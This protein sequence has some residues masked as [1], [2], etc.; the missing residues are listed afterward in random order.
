MPLIPL[1]EGTKTPLSGTDVDAIL[2]GD[3][4]PEASLRIF[5]KHPRLNYGVACRN[6]LFAVDFD[7][8]EKYLV[9]FPKHQE[10][11]A[12]TM[13]VLSPHR[14]C[15]VW[16]RSSEEIRR[17]LGLAKSLDV[18]ALGG[19]AV[20]PASVLDHAKCPAD[21]I[22]CPHVGLGTYA[23]ID[24]HSIMWAEAYFPGV[25]IVAKLE[26]RAKALG[27]DFRKNG[28]SLR[29]IVKQGAAPGERHEA[30]KKYAAHLIWTV[31]LD[32]DTALFELKRWDE[33][34]N[35]PPISSDPSRGHELQSIIEWVADRGPGARKSHVIQEEDL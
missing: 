9:F 3:I 8:L 2:A 4:S 13:I 33:K 25:S 5:E 28:P 31:K 35:R 27:W 23:V 14:G 15:H 22:G 6:G 17:Q 20:G 26:E 10:L 19:Y 30:A 21:K 18:L 11:E 12:R 34:T 32:A 16:L 1:A 29:K 7:D 24:A